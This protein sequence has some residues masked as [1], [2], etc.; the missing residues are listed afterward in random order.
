MLPELPA[1]AIMSHH[2]QPRRAAPLLCICDRWRLHHPASC[3]VCNRAL[4]FALSLAHS[5]T[6]TL[7][8]L[9]QRLA[10][11]ANLLPVCFDLPDRKSSRFKS[12]A[13]GHLFDSVCLPVRLAVVSK[14]SRPMMIATSR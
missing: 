14:Q 3:A 7:P 4:A 9:L 1:S 13:N 5:L 11:G 2:E 12:A 10:S 8:P 6:W